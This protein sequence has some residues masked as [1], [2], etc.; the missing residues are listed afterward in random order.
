MGVDAVDFFVFMQVTVLIAEMSVILNLDSFVSAFFIVW[1]QASAFNINILIQEG[2]KEMNE[3][4]SRGG[5][6]NG[7]TA[8]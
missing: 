5:V 4:M 6:D 3:S 8:P 1:K 2:E 7:T